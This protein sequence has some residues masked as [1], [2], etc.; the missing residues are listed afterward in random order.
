MGA[1]RRPRDLT[2]RLPNEM[3]VTTSVVRG[4]PEPLPPDRAELRQRATSFKLS[5]RLDMSCRAGLFCARDG[6]GPAAAA[7]VLGLRGNPATSR[8]SRRDG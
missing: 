3:A 6:Q 4:V 2:P 8:A 7:S 5:M 1:N